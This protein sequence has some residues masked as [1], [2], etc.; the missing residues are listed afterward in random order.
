MGCADKG[1]GLRDEA[2]EG[3]G[4]DGVDV[5]NGFVRAL[6]AALW[7]RDRGWKA[8][9]LRFSC[10]L[11]GGVTW[12]SLAAAGTA[13]SVGSARSECSRMQHA[14]RAQMRQW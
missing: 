14:R 1:T 11:F 3:N 12:Q 13:G 5:E 8:V 9:E 6:R 4:V 7:A 2:S 10:S